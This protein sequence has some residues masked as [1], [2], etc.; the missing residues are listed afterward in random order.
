MRKIEQ[1]AIDRKGARDTLRKE[2][3]KEKNHNFLD[4]IIYTRLF[5]GSEPIHP[6]HRAHHRYSGICMAKLYFRVHI[7][8]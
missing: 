7:G 8:T 3:E 6:Y 1:E 5:L 4:L 2:R